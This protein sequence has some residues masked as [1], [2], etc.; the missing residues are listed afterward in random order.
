[1]SVPDKTVQNTDN[2]CPEIASTRSHLQQW[3]DEAVTLADANPGP[4][5]CPSQRQISDWS[6][7]IRDSRTGPVDD[8]TD[9][10]SWRDEVGVMSD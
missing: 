3:F 10:D 9:P 6:K 8:E 7:I 1:M 5:W 4:G 2:G